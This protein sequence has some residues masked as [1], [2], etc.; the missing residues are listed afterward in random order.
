M[1]TVR[2][3]R[4]GEEPSMGAGRGIRWPLGKSWRVVLVGAAAILV[5]L[6]AASSSGA[7]GPPDRPASIPTGPG[8]AGPATPGA[9][10]AAEQRRHRDEWLHS[11]A[12]R[13]ER[14]ESRRR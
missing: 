2:A 7:D 10:T 1:S 9:A 3:A 13:Q 11:P 5:G 12:A 6:L 8:S 4:P 14:A